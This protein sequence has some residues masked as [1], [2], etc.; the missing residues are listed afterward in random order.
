MVLTP[1]KPEGVSL[2]TLH[3]WGASSHQTS[4]NIYLDLQRGV[5]S[6]DPGW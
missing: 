4:S 6:G 2:G 5:L 3:V 1:P